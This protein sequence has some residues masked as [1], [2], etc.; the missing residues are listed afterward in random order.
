M[1][2]AIR[3]ES[4]ILITRFLILLTVCAGI[5]AAVLGRWYWFQTRPY[6]HGPDADLSWHVEG[7]PYQVRCTVVDKEGTPIPGVDVH[8]DNN[9]G[10]NGKQTDANGVANLEMGEPEVE[11][12]RLNDVPVL[13]KPWAGLLGSPSVQRGLALEITVKNRDILT[14]R[15]P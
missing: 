5:A 3:N 8:V 13:N 15:E 12:I 9:S 6:V 1:S 4:Q 7:K 2:R 10:G 14:K 11:E